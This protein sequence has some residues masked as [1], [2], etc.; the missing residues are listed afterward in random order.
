MKTSEGIDKLAAA[1]SAAQGEMPSAA[2]NA[3]NPFLKNRYADLNAITSAIKPVLK[4]HGLAYVQMPTASDD[5]IGLTTRLMHSS[6]Q[7]LE[8]TFVMPMPDGEKGKSVMQVAGSAIT[9][10]RRY[11]LAAMLGMVADEDSD[12][13]APAKPQQAANGKRPPAQPVARN[14]PPPPPPDFF[15]EPSQA[16]EA[17]EVRADILAQTIDGSPA[18]ASDKQLKYMRSSLG[19]LVGNDADKAKTVLGYLFNVASSTELTAAQASAIIN[20]AGANAANKYTVEPS[21]AQEAER[22]VTAAYVDEG[23]KPL[24]D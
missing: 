4:K 20:W 17:D 3:V 15:D 18:N 19:S 13:N 24:F 11:A 10:A 5:G 16:R 2:M 23:Q 8:D 7:W 1:L 14:N 12:G 9:Y 6:G 22:I 21:A